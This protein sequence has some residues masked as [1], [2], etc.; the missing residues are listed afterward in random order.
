MS[1]AAQHN[2]VPI[3]TLRVSKDGYLER[4]VTDDQSLYPARRWHFVHRIVW[5][6]A[7]G[8]IPAGHMVVFRRGQ[9]TN[10]VELLTADRLECISFKENALRN[11]YWKTDPELMKLYQ[12]KGAITRHVNRMKEEQNA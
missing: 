12:L 10:D 7:N 4:K 6:A 8:P 1:G 3:G 5:E 11:S 2:Y 9:F